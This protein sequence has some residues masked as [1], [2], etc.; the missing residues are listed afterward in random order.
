[1]AKSRLSHVLG[2]AT[3]QQLFFAMARHVISTVRRVQRVERTLVVTPSPSVCSFAI[4]MGCEV[5]MQKNNSGTAEAFEVGVQHARSLGAQ[6]L[7][8]LSGDLPLLT[9][10]AID[11]LLA[12]AWAPD[13]VAIAPDTTE[14][15]TNA[16]ALGSK[17]KLPMCFGHESYQRHVE[18]A[19]SRGLT[20]SV[21]R[22]AELATDIDE[23]AHLRQF[24]RWI[25]SDPSITVGNRANLMIDALA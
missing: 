21:V 14:T 7:L 6:A 19:H 25:L 18:A 11:D 20:V 10:E 2:P 1:M 12:A 17:A 24:S 16:M 5:I 4:D 15:G 13:A 8:L 9:P 23:E 22:R 3:R